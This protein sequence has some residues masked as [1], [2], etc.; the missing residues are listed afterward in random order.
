[1]KSSMNLGILHFI[2]KNIRDF[3]FVLKSVMITSEIFIRGIYASDKFYEIDEL[4][5]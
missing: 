2:P 3:A 4:P 1:M 5:S